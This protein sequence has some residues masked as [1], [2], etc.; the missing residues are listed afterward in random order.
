MRIEEIFAEKNEESEAE[1]TTKDEEENEQHGTE[2]ELLKF[3]LEVAEN[4]KTLNKKTLEAIVEKKS[5]Y[6][7]VLKEL[8]EHLKYVLLGNER[9][10]PV[11]ITTDL[12]LEKEKEVVETLKQ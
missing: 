6:G 4:E 10:Q 3:M 9:S 8:P 2:E 1:A 12:T 5:S 7:L 11:I